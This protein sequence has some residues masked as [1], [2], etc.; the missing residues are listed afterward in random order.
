ML[1]PL[2]VNI[3][4]VRVC[5]AS[6]LY[7]SFSLEAAAALIVLLNPLLPTLMLPVDAQIV[8]PRDKSVSSDKQLI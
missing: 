5:L 1:L 4:S 8:S 7:S 2:S 3:C 6:E